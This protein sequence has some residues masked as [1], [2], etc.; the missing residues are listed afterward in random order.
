MRVFG[1][2]RVTVNF[3]IVPALRGSFTT[4]QHTFILIVRLV[5]FRVR[6]HWR[7]NGIKIIPGRRY[8]FQ[9]TNTVNSR[10]FISVASR[11]FHGVTHRF[12]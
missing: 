6:H 10:D 11:Q 7:E 1:F 3:T 8:G 9:Y 2:R 4:G 5:Q 12:Q